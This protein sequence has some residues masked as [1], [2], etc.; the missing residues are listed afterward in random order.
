MK[1]GGQVEP[2]GG[3][4]RR[5]SDEVSYS[6]PGEPLG[7]ALAAKVAYDRN[8]E[9][10]E[11]LRYEWDLLLLEGRELAQHLIPDEETVLFDQSRR[12]HTAWSKFR[13]NLPKD[14]EIQLEGRD[15]PD[16]NYLVATVKKASATWQSDRDGSKLGKLKDKFHSLCETCQNH[17]SLLEI[18]PKDEKY[19][20]LLTGSLSA[21]AQAT[22]NH[23]K[24]AEGVADTLDDLSQ[25]I[26]F[27]NRQVEEHGYTSS[28]RRYIQE[29]YVV[30][31]EFF[32]E[33]F[34]KWSKSGWKR[35][36][37]S[38]D[39]S[40]FN[41]LFTAR[42]DRLTVIEQQ[43]QRQVDF[44]FR[45][46]TRLKLNRL[47][48][49]YEEI[50][51][52][53]PDQLHKQRLVLGEYLQQF[54]EQ[55]Q[56]FRLE[57]SQQ[58]LVTST[59]EESTGKTPDLSASDGS[60]LPSPDLEVR[61]RPRVHFR[62]S[63]SEIQAE[64]THFTTQW[65]NQ[66]EHLIQAAKQASSL[67]IDK[68]VHYR[69]ETWLRGFSS[70][71]LWIQ[72]PHDVSRP[73]QNTMTAV[74]LTALART[75]NIPCVIYFCTLAD[76]RALAESKTAFLRTFIVSI[77][78]QL[79]QLMPEKGYSNVDLSPARFAALTQDTLNVGEA[80]QLMRDVRD[81]GPRL[82]HGFI[83]NI[84]VLE[85]RSDDGYTRDFLSAIATLCRLKGRS[86]LSEIVD[87]P[88]SNETVLGTKICFTTEGYVDGLAQAVG[89]Q[90]AEKVEFGLDLS[91]PICGVVGEGIKWD[92]QA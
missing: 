29:L 87:S 5:F 20:T 54:L 65:M 44:E 49:N 88:D 86:Q 50:S 2:S 46:N 23:Q 43:M 36:L 69:V 17:S 35:F 55:Q 4:I 89:L 12:L 16:I 1:R 79:V 40:A 61:P 10:S 22:I 72:G 71:N 42:K 77:I 26:D 83:D 28:L 63:R 24:I 76:Q 31:F 6:S 19:V 18:I 33:I 68:E 45:R 92:H 85:D 30:V 81:L 32:T 91:D 67:Q 27:W 15:L 60:E 21:I 39:E 64:L 3:I 52:S 38:F 90:L 59:I 53:L 57:K 8:Q 62:Y 7:R 84:Q 82:V 25:D 11:S 58:A 70:T 9:R 74:S 34:N 14:Q 48:Q 47:V 73:G 56:S 13:H 37:T 75:H 51:T 41:K 66:V 78:T 80:L